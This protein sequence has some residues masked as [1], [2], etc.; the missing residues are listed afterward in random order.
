[1]K[2]FKEYLEIIE[3]AKK[4][5]TEG[6]TPLETRG[7]DELIKY[8]YIIKEIGSQESEKSSIKH[9]L[10]EIKQKINPIL[11]KGNLEYFTIKGIKERELLDYL[12]S[13]KD[14][15]DRLINERMKSLEE[16]NNNTTIRFTSKDEEDMMSDYSSEKEKEDLESGNTYPEEGGYP[17][18]RR[19]KRHYKN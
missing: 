5:K 6:A 18:N 12:T 9:T 4:S 14:N 13:A 3:E 1:M 7:K 11:S 8:Y 10:H 15:I 19:L 2:S 17:Q 16:K